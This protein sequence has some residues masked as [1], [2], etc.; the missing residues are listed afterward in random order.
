M[1]SFMVLDI[2]DCFG[3]SGQNKQVPELQPKWFLLG[4]PRGASYSQGERGPQDKSTFTFM[5][6]F[7]IYGH[8]ERH[9]ICV[10]SIINTCQQCSGIEVGYF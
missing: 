3:R 10:Q 9:S 4:T 8:S 1:I 5:T 2:R 7:R 6:I